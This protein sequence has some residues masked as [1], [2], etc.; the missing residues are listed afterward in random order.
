M[1]SGDNLRFSAIKKPIL[2]A[3]LLLA[4]WLGAQEGGLKLRQS[5]FVRF[6]IAGRLFLSG[7][8]PYSLPD[9]LRLGAD[10]HLSPNPRGWMLFNPPIAL[11][12]LGPFA[13]LPFTIAGVIWFGLQFAAVFLSSFWLWRIY[14]GPDRF[15]W[16]AV[17]LP[18]TFL[19]IYAALVD[20]QMTPLVLLGIVAFLYFTGKRAFSFAGA[21]LALLALKPQLCLTFEFVLLLWCL[22]ERKWKLL[23]A[24]AAA[25]AILLLPVCFRPVLISQYREVI[26]R[27]WEDAAPAW[28]GVLRAAFGYQRVWLQYLP[29]VPGLTWAAL[30]WKKYRSSWDWQQR[31]P[32]LLLVGFITAPYAWTYD[33]VILLPVFIAAAVYLVAA[34]DRRLAKR[35]FGFYLLVNLAMFALNIL[36]SRDIWFLWNLPVWLLAY[37]LLGRHSMIVGLPS[38]PLRARDVP[39]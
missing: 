35:V 14:R 11:T 31:L 3:L 19:P 4:L 12:V 32:M 28:G 29:L 30:Y 8:N 18:G 5:D 17:A 26:P 16:L 13:L 36:G 2:L 38:N 33:E 6:W 21:A 37:M 20:C 27:I 34:P 25:T 39:A 7:T 23:A 24:L 9:V 15:R 10:L 22:R 1:V